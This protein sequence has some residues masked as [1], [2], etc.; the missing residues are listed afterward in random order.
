MQCFGSYHGRGLRREKVRPSRDH[1][2]G[3][4]APAKLAG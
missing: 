1:F 4:L 2:Q 3:K